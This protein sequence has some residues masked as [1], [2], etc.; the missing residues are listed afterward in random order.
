M[1]YDSLATRLRRPLPLAITFAAG[2]ALSTL[3]PA[4]RFIG[5]ATSVAFVIVTSRDRRFV[6]GIALAIGL[7]IGTRPPDRIPSGVTIDDRTTDH[8]IGE[9]AGP[10][11]TTSHGT[12]ARLDTDD[13]GSI[14][15]WLDRET[16][17]EETGDGPQFP[18]SDNRTPDTTSGVKL[19]ADRTT[20]QPA[21]QNWSN[22]P[23]RED[24]GDRPQSLGE[25]VDSTTRTNAIRSRRAALIP[26][27]RVV[28]S[29]RAK[30]PGGSRGPGMVP[31]RGPTVEM[32]VETIE[33]VD[34]EPGPI[35]R[36]WRWARETQ[37]AWGER[38]DDAGGDA[39]ARAALRGIVTGDRSA[40]PEELD[41][42]WRATGIFHVL[43]V[44]GLHL[45]VIAGL[46]FLFLRKLVAGSP[47]GGRLRPARWAAPP[48]LVIAIVY[49]LVTGA[50]LATL[51]ALIV[52]VLMLVGAM[53]DRPL[54]LLDAIGVAAIA[55]LVWRPMDLFDPSFQLSF[56]AAIVLALV[57]RPRATGVKGWI[58]RGVATSMWVTIA[59][60]PITAYHFHQVTPSGVIGNLVLTPLLEVIALPVALVGIALGPIGWPFVRIATEIVSVV[61]RIAEVGAHVAIIGRVAIGNTIVF[62]ALVAVSLAL[63]A[64]K[65]RMVKWIVLCVVWSLARSP[66]PLGAL[67]VTFL[68]VGQGDAA[69]VELPDGGVWLVDAGGH[70]SA[71]SLARASET[72]AIVERA[73]AVAGHGRVDLAIVSHPHP[74]HYSGLAG[75]RTPI[76]ELWSAAE[77]EGGTGRAFERVAAMLLA[78]GTRWVHPPL[79]IAIERA[80]VQLVVWAPRYEGAIAASDPV[81]TVNDNSL[82]VELRFAGRSIVFA[83]DLEL[84]GEEL[85]VGAG[86]GHADVVKVAH[87]GS[88]TSSSEAFVAR[89]A[90]EV[91]VIS[92]GRGNAFGFPSP[93]VVARWRAV[94]AEVRRTDSGAVTVV[95]DSA[96]ALAIDR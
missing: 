42:R 67:R 21:G 11:I 83:G 37:V 2:I 17:F 66:A 70:A 33:I 92:C 49:T 32:A 73:L 93:D 24:G 26:G 22:P 6:A 75:M 88:P 38:I 29:G 35:D 47:W 95:V 58:A 23:F 62:V 72:G 91:A 41:A 31:R 68:D 78:R 13:G 43:S 34:D 12:G 86:I 90:P 55:I 48:A 71:G 85:V 59:T 36:A 28:V 96:G 51:R 80:G 9:I 16:P 60:A 14:W 74:D 3:V 52:I 64:A 18:A 7:M 40:V 44:S 19:S 69:L 79:G 15:L 61:D 63:V 20:V 45:A 4:A 39:T 10:I 53:L 84:E 8:V 82:V 94:G 87:H 27:M 50:Q 57:K 81:R 1:S 89:T 46:A 25:L 56:T 76:A 30:S 5:L 77:P 54:R 65:Q